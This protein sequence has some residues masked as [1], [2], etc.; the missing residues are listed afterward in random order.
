MLFT[1]DFDIVPAPISQTLHIQ[2]VV[3][4]P[5]LSSK[6]A[7]PN[8]GSEAAAS[9]TRSTI[10]APRPQAKGLKMRYLPLGYVGGDSG[11]VL[12]DSDSEDDD[13]PQAQAGLAAPNGLNLPTKAP[14]RKHTEAIGEEAPSK[15]IKK[16]RTPEEIKKREE[17]RAKKDKKSKA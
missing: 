9:I 17:K 11:G 13:V 7:D 8:T 10:R 6:Q 12:G 5:K 2:Q 1:S 3:S 4:L 15:K 14:K 16:H